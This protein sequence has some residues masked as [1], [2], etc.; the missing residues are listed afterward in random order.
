ML[1]LRGA[2]TEQRHRGQGA[3]FILGTVV[4][5]ARARLVVA[6]AKMIVAC[7]FQ[8][9]RQHEQEVKREYAGVS[10]S[11]RALSNR[12]PSRLMTAEVS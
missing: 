7:R 9:R 3:A 2:W 11:H 1:V 10:E 4:D 5:D 8:Q 12:R 6:F